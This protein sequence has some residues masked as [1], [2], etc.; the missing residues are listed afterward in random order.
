MSDKKW[1]EYPL[2]ITVL[3]LEVEPNKE[4]AEMF[5]DGLRLELPGWMLPEY[6]ASM[7]SIDKTP[8]GKPDKKDLHLHLGV[9]QY[10]IVE[11]KEPD[12]K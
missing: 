8:V 1:G 6:W 10:S 12:E 2:A 9:G 11:L 5:R 3:M 7:D 4:A